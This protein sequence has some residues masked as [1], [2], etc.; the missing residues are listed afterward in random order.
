MGSKAEE[1]EMHRK[2]R[3]GGRIGEE[4]EMERTE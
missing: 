1:E 2:W 3:R 4:G